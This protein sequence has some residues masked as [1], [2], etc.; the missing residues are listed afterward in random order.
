MSERGPHERTS[1][2]VDRHLALDD[3]R[4]VGQDG[5]R[6]L[7]CSGRRLCRLRLLPFGLRPCLRRPGRCG[8][9]TDDEL[10]EA[11]GAAEDVLD[12]LGLSHV[13]AV[14]RQQR[15]AHVD[16][17]VRCRQA[18][19][20]EPGHHRRLVRPVHVRYEEPKLLCQR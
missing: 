7:E 17:A 4:R 8:G 14:R 2:G 1:A 15:V 16:A 20:L 3:R 11:G 12:P 19:L 9:G 10:D 6:L 13:D 5:L 18:A